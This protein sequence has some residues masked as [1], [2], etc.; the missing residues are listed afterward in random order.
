[1]RGTTSRTAARS[2]TIATQARAS[3]PGSRT[4]P[5]ARNGSR[6]LDE[7]RGFLGE[8]PGTLFKDRDDFERALEGAGKKAG[9]K[10][11]APAAKTILSALSERDEKY[12]QVGVVGWGRVVC[13][14]VGTSC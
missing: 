2:R 8:L 10:L 4:L 1:M 11:S 5:T 3:I 9:L 13:E 14:T 6:A 7:E 12:R